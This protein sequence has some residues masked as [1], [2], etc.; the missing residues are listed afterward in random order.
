MSIFVKDPAA[1]V[2]HAID[3]GSAFLA[4][5]SITAA[6]WSVLPAG[7]LS[8]SNAR[9]EAGRTAITLTGGAVGQ[10]YRVTGRVTLSD[11][12]NDERTLVVRVEDR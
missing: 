2:D 1:S 3:W 4:G 6:V 7:A 5:R 12:S 11:G 8:L 9:S 10:I